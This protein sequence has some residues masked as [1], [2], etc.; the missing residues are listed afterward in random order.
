MLLLVRSKSLLFAF[1]VLSEK[2]V[3]GS[4]NTKNS[5]IR[6]LVLQEAE[7]VSHVDGPV[8][9]IVMSRTCPGEVSASRQCPSPCL[10]WDH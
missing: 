7:F 6:L 2:I 8:Y 4:V 10:P 5:Y 1:F 9:T 3:V